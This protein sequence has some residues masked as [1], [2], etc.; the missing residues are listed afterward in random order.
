MR[1]ERFRRAP[2][3]LGAVEINLVSYGGPI[4]AALVGWLLL[5]ETPSLVTW[6]GFVIIFAGFVLIKRAA[7]RQELPRLRREFRAALQWR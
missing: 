2:E 4:W 7:I 5:A 3:R 6:I 1:N